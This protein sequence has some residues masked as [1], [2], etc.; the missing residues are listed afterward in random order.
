M[1]FKKQFIHIVD[2]GFRAILVSLLV[3]S[4]LTTSPTRAAGLPNLTVNM[5][6]NG[7]NLIPLETGRTFTIT[8][9][10]IGDIPTTGPATVVFSEDTVPI[11][12]TVTSISGTDW[13]CTLGTLSCTRSDFLNNGESYSDITVTVTVLVGALPEVITKAVVSG[14]GSDDDPDNNTWSVTSDVNAKADLRIIG[15]ELRNA[16][17]SAVITKP[18]P[19]ETFWVRMT[20]QNQGGV[21]GGVSSLQFYTSVFLDDKPNYGADHDSD[22]IALPPGYPVTLTLGETTDYQGYKVTNASAQ[23]G[24]GCVYYDPNNQINP[25]ATEVLTERGNYHPFQFLPGLAAGATSTYDVEINYPEAQYSDPIY[26]G[27]IRTGLPAGS[28]NIY[29]Y[30][31]PS[32]QVNEVAETNNAYGPIPVYVGSRVDVTIGGNFISDYYL[33][34]SA[35]QR[36]NYP[37]LDAGP[38][39]IESISG[40]PIIAALREAWNNQQ[41]GLLSSTSFAQ[42]M[43]IP[44]EQLSD[45]YYLPHYNDLSPLLDAQLRIG[46]V[47]TT[48]AT[49]AIT[50][51]GVLQETVNIAPG[52]SYRVNYPTLDAGPVKV[53]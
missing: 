19:N 22:G 53:E 12:L 17:K 46:N 5:V 49:V 38:V 3:L 26:D 1:N 14:G 25:V 35:S 40:A 32:C 50:I 16:D 20:I 23:N 44:A 31:D 21:G 39:K 42:L 29:L 24:A 43:G 15:Y 2:R 33:A 34:T 18:E 45:T 28:Y 11:G 52:A 13:N 41:T 36:V 37:T 10:N 4:F 7:G 30:A 27:I 48:T 6:L 47:D 51:G 8:V 9:S